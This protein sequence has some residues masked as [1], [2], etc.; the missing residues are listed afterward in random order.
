MPDADFQKTALAY[1]ERVRSAAGFGGDGVDEFPDLKAQFGGK[2]GTAL[3]FA[4]YGGGS[5]FE[6]NFDGFAGAICFRDDGGLGSDQA[7][8]GGAD[9]FGVMQ[10]VLNAVHVA[11]CLLYQ[12]GVEAVDS[13]PGFG[14]F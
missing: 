13:S 2:G 1:R 11:R 10:E 3:Y 8:I 4:L 6:W 9:V 12:E 14:R 7:G 5:V